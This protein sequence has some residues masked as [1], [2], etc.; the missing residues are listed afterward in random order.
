MPL[1][2]LFF[3]CGIWCCQQGAELPRMEALLGCSG[4]IPVVLW[5]RQRL[6]ALGGRAMI[7][8]LMLWL[9]AALAGYVWAAGFGLVR[10]ADHL[11]AE[12]EGRD[13]AVIGVVSGLPQRIDRGERFEFQVE[14]V[15]RDGA[16]RLAL[17]PQHISLAWYRGR[18]EAVSEE[19]HRFRSVHAGERWRLTVR[20]KQP[21]GNLN[22]H[23]LDME[24][25]LF[26]RG[27]RATGYVR[28]QNLQYDS[29]RLDEQVLRPGLM[30]ERLREAVRE[31]IFTALPEGAYAGVLAA[32][33]MGDQQAIDA[34]EWALF[35]KV[36]I[37]HLVS[38]SGLHVT[39]IASLGYGLVG[40]FWRRSRLALRLPTQKAAALAGAFTAWAYC[41]L[42]GYGVPAQRTFYMLA[43]VAWALWC[44]RQAAGRQVLALALGLVLLLDPLA[45]LSAGFWLSFGAVALLFY[46]ASGR[47]QAGHWLREWG[48]AQW[49][50]TLGM[51]PALLALFQQFSLVSPLANVLAIPLITFIVTPLALFGAV[52]PFDSVLLLA[53]GVLAGLMAAMIW[54]AALPIAVWQQA[55]PP[56]WAVVLAM[57]GCLWLLLPRGWPVRWLGL[58]L[59]LPLILLRPAR[60]EMGGMAVTV[61]DVGQGLALHVQTAGHDLIY[62]T[63]PQFSLD[64][65]SGNRIILPYLRSAGVAALDALV[66]THQDMD[67]AGGAAAVLQGLPVSWWASS[68]PP[69]HYLRRM[70]GHR[71]CFAG[72][73]WQWDGVLFEM[74]YPSFEAYAL[75]EKKTNDRSCVLRITAASGRILLTSD[76]EALSEA[77]LLAEQAEQ[78][79]TEVMLMPH[80]GSRT[81]STPAFIDAAAA[82]T[83]IIPV[84][85]RSRY[86]HPV[87]EVVERYRQRGM[88]VWRTDLLGAVRLIFAQD[89]I[90]IT[91]E[92]QIQRRYW[93]ARAPQ[94]GTGLD[95]DQAATTAGD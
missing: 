35:A 39:L 68:L 7:G 2:V 36:G 51:M 6:L 33:V 70:P 31:R 94:S 86:G 41:L 29:Q 79:R 21:H 22:P 30:L 56:A 11:G 95:G 78:L 84:G 89:R 8:R 59:F 67:H 44:G 16:G 81:S 82:Q 1:A 5:R 61:L 66:V 53:H 15:L 37:T 93:H 23:G 54:L 74:L 69:E 19:D 27:I 42:A 26:E 38:I 65:N 90:E 24:A 20:L 28:S 46:I 58:A 60:P 32:L 62:D 75:A 77:R 52:L 92:R 57:I 45:V 10:L 83:V 34:E 13:I 48:R 12:D 40:F 17:V 9:A 47:L 14:Q 25:W 71:P 72:Q 87:P 91:G 76:I 73:R 43:V 4:V 49:A 85:Y 80:H 88:A 50:V 18:Q 63:G 55:A 64:A 3:T